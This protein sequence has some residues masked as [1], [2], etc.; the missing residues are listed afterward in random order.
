MPSVTSIL[1]VVDKGENF[2]KWVASHASYD[3]ACQVRD[4]AAS[5]RLWTRRYQKSYVF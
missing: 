3:I 4:A 1:S 5:K 2:L